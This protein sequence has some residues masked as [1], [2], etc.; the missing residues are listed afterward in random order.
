MADAAAVLI[1]VDRRSNIGGYC[2]WCAGEIPPPGVWRGRVVSRRWCSTPCKVA[3]HN[4][5]LAVA[6]AATKLAVTAE[7][8]AARRWPASSGRLEASGRS[9]GGHQVLEFDD[10]PPSHEPSSVQALTI[11]PR[12]RGGVAE[13]EIVPDLGANPQVE[14]GLREEP[15]EDGEPAS[16]TYKGIVTQDLDT[17]ETALLP[18]R[19]DA[20]ELARRL[21]EASKAK[22]RAELE[23]RKGFHKAKAAKLRGARGALACM[24]IRR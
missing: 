17:G 3:N 19:D 2:E 14:A 12:G 20:D 16:K 5:E 10:S 6:R 22:S 9:M 15:D 8:P 11:T 1:L 7:A 4:R 23:R 24:V 13:E 18:V 21:L